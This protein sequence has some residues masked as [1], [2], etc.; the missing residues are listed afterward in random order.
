MNDPAWSSNRGNYYHALPPHMGMKLAREIATIT[1]RSRPEW[2]QRFGRR[3]AD[4]SKPPAL[5]PDFL[6]ETYLDHAGEKWCLDFDANSLL[7]ISKAMDL[8]DLG[9]DH[10]TM[11]TKNRIANAYKLESHNRSTGQNDGMCSLALPDKPYEERPS[12]IRLDDQV[13][14]SEDLVAG[15]T[16]TKKIPALVIGVVSDMLFPASQ[17]R[18]VADTMKATGNGNVKYIELG[19]DHSLFGHDTFLLDPQGMGVEMRRFLN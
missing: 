16:P 15:L 1:Y 17:Q 14:V 7:Y 5:C 18:E 6:I 12:N 4:P 13:A 8:F 11:L 3:R 19:E 10:M 2:D 9:A